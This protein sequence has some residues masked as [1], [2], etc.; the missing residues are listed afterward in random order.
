MQQIYHAN[1]KTNINIRTELQNNSSSPAALALRFNISEQTVSKWKYRNFTHDSS[2]K[3]N[4]I[5]YALSETEKALAISLRTSSWASMD[6][7][8]ESLLLINPKISRISVY[9]CFVKEKINRIPEQNKEKA[10]QFKEYQRG[11]LV[12]GIYI[13]M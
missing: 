7:I 13:L 9:R 5:A 4:H 2:C 3:P 8:W 6:D 12:Q 11:R 1:A 10:K